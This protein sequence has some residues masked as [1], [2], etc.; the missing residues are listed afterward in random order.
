[1]ATTNEVEDPKPA[2]K[3]RRRV[4]PV[5][6]IG[7]L[8]FSSLLH[9]FKV[10]LT[11]VL[12]A[13]PAFCVLPFALV[14]TW[15]ARKAKLAL[16]VVWIVYAVALV[17]ETVFFSRMLTPTQDGSITVVSLNCAGGVPNAVQQIKSA[18]PDLILLQESPNEPELR[19]L[20]KELYGEEGSYVR[21]PD[22]SIIARGTLEAVEP[23]KLINCTPA[24]WTY[25]G[26][27][28]NV[29]SLRLTPPVMR[30]DLYNS[31]A[32]QDF[33]RNRGSR[34]DEVAEMEN[35]LKNAGFVPEII[36]GDFNTPP[37]QSTVDPL[38]SGYTD[39]FAAAGRGYG[40][41]CVSPYPLMVRIDYIY[42]SKLRAVFAET[43]FVPSSD[44]RAVVAKFN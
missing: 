32:W 7:L 27:T 4:S 28:R 13:W 41:T 30:I 12:W 20:A 9:I 37:D 31:E 14:L 26:V 21:G 24:R 44:H 35:L 39:A 11:Y 36:G 38:V 10:D 5:W 16:S 15:R 8:I 1:M 43:M 2:K 29:L 42:S 25:K 22:A 6:S 34:R 19:E 33:A 40:A 23:K 3:K 18:N 17:P